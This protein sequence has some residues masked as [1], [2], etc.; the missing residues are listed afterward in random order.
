MADVKIFVSVWNR[1]GCTKQCVQSLIATTR[2]KADIILFDNHSTT[3]A[4]SLWSLYRRWML[5]GAVAQIVWNGAPVLTSAFW[6][7]NY[8][9][10]Q[11][12][13]L[14]DLIEP[15]ER[16]FLVMVDNDVVFHPRWLETSLDI[17]TSEAARDKGVVVVSPYDGV[18]NPS[19]DPD[20]YHVIE[21][22]SVAGHPVEIR[23]AVA[24]RAWVARGDFWTRWPP[25][26]WKEILRN[27]RP[28]RMPTDTYYWQKMQAEGLRFAVMTPPASVDP[29]FPWRSARLQRRIGDDAR[30]S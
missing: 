24:S 27:G 11:F 8:A 16:R 26:T 10:A 29:P 15:D 25:P 7:K 18:P 23:N 22:L 17:L 2:G 3:D 12:L 14:V 9:W 1:A 5:Q 4:R 6:S 13:N 20:T 28:D 21:R 30:R 19:T